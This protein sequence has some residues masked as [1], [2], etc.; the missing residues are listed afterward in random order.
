VTIELTGTK[1]ITPGG[2]FDAEASLKIDHPE[3]FHGTIDLHNVSLADL[4]GLAEADS[5][6]F[7]NDMLSIK[8]ACGTVI[9]KL[10]VVSDASST[11]GIHG[12][13][14]SMSPAGDVLI[15]PGADFH[16]TLALPNS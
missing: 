8:N 5:W 12:L 6:S 3:D 10:H 13:S 16:G 14:V 1:I 9:D 7:R 15:R 2:P 11:N 4:V